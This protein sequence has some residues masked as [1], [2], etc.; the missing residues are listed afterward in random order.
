[1]AF[2]YYA[3]F[4]RNG[5]FD[6]WIDNDNEDFSFSYLADY[7]AKQANFNEPPLSKHPITKTGGAHGLSHQD[8]DIK[9]VIRF[10]LNI[11][12]NQKETE[13][14]YYF[15][16]DEMNRGIEGANHSSG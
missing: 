13:A 8:D 1:M 16:Q 2:L 4:S 10:K 11:L 5:E 9:D 7:M 15:I 14:F 3:Y 12:Y 6:Y